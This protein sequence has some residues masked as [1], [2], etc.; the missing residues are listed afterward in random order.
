MAAAPKTWTELIQIKAYSS[1]EVPELVKTF[2]KLKVSGEDEGLGDITLLRNYSIQ[3][4]FF[5]RLTWHGVMPGKGKS[6]LGYQLA[7]AFSVFGFIYHSVWMR[8][9]SLFIPREKGNDRIS[10]TA[11]N[12]TGMGNTGEDGPV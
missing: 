6:V 8:E 5:I 7:R 12:D 11:R 4:D 2:Y 1:L 3:N 9:T 10:T